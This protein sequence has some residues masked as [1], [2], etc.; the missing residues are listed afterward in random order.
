M[1]EI[2][3]QKTKVNF[4][5]FIKYVI[6][7]LLL[8]ISSFANI[9]NCIYP[10][11]FGLYFAFLWC[12]QDL[13]VLSGFYIL[14]NYITYFSL[15]NLL[16]SL[17]TVYI[18]IMAFLLHKKFKKPI[19]VWLLCIYAFVSKLFSF[20]YIFNNS[21]QIV[22]NV[23]GIFLG[24][25]FMLACIKI[26]K[27]ILVRGVA[28]KLTVDEWVSIGFIL[29]VLSLG[30]SNITILHIN[31]LNV[32]SIFLILLA[33]YI[34]PS[35]YGVIIGALMGVGSAIN[36]GNFN[37]I[38]LFTMFGIV[39]LL[40]KNK[41]KYFSVLAVLLC[42]IV[43]GLYF[44]V[45]GT[46]SIFNTVSIILGEVAFLV[47]SDNVIKT[48]QVMIGG[49]TS[50]TAIRNVVNRSRDG[51]C[52]RMY[53]IS[54]VFFDMNNVFRG[55]IRGLL[56]AEQAREMLIMEIQQNV[57]K[58]CPERH[59]CWR[60]LNAETNQVFADILNAGFE[61]GKVLILDIPPFLNS[62]CNRTTMLLSVINQLLVSYKQYTT[63]VTN[64]DASRVLIAEQL[65]GVSKLLRVLAD[66][67]KQNVSFD[68]SKENALIEELNFKNIVCSE[69]IL[70]EQN[71]NAINVTLLVRTK[72]IIKEEIEK[73]CS[74]LCYS[75]MIITD[76]SKS[77]TEG[78]S[79]LELKTAPK[80]DIIFG[81]SGCNKNGDTVSGDTYTFLKIANDKVLLAVCDGMGSGNSAKITSDT[82]IS[83]IENF[84]KAGFDNDIA[85]SSINKLL[86]L[87]AD[88]KFSAIDLCVIDLAQ[89]SADFVKLGSPDCFIK[90]KEEVET[91]KCNALPLGILEEVNPTI[92]K[93]VVDFNDMIILCS[94][95]VVDSFESSEAF[96]LFLN[97][98]NST[99]PQIISDAILQKVVA[100]YQNNPKDDCTI[101]CARVF[102]RV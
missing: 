84:Y 50:Q 56:P 21:Q 83:L 19:K 71:A 73:I 10:F 23:I 101:I 43:F 67:T 30:L 9:K 54:Q 6:I 93:K 72:D 64:M 20:Y 2:F 95:G 16:V 70:Y 68:V 55:L 14:I 17:F 27:Y 4:I 90:H 7:F 40:F 29:I 58:D 34:Y 100:N 32:I 24:I 3:K 88:D 91:L 92:I 77:T 5:I 12:E 52:K 44:K 13:F 8:L 45:Y 35:G 87:N 61:R 60:V 38:A 33:T 31:I 82:A 51:L 63:M 86:S 36:A 53:E 74:K 98:L 1:R 18:A 42:E 25:L 94:D 65:E 41:I 57:C 69:A 49:L 11:A 37:F 96:C 89:S 97:T 48:L 28:L 81:C 47:I 46:Y 99:N 102:V 62:R 76:I 85:L 26:F 66:E 59:K 22:Y 75:K 78:F 79:V 80:Y 15:N 39:S